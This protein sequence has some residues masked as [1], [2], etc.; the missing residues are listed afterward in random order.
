MGKCYVSMLS[1]CKHQTYGRTDR[2]TIKT[3]CPDLSMQGHKKRHNSEK[4]ALTHYHT[5]PHFDPLKIYGCG[6]HCEK[7]RNCL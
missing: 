4:D 2:R 5:I 3:I 7:R 6:K 1:L